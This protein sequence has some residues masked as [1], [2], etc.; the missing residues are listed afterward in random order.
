MRMIAILLYCTL[1]IA[2][3]SEAQQEN[4][5]VKTKPGIETLATDPENAAKTNKIAE[6]PGVQEYLS[7]LKEE[8]KDVPNPFIATYLGSEW[9]D[10]FYFSFEDA[11]GKYHDFGDGKN[12]LGNLAFGENDNESNSDLVGKEFIIT[13]EWKISHFACCEGSMESHEGQIPGITGIELKNK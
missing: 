12:E 8:M 5:P 1:I 11:S 9:G 10:Y 4:T 2:G 3:K 13:W 7:N 6:D